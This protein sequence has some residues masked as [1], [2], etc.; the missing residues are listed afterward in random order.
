MGNER[1]I[2]PVYAPRILT[3][4]VCKKESN[5]NRAYTPLLRCRL[6]CDDCPSSFLLA[7]ATLEPPE[8]HTESRAYTN[9]GDVVGVSGA[10]K[11]IYHLTNVPTVR[12]MTARIRSQTAWTY[13]HSLG[14]HIV[15]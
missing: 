4:P 5:D 6:V 7:L 8:N 11:R 1:I 3:I 14:N 15:S 12:V 13:E 9:R 2:V 10:P